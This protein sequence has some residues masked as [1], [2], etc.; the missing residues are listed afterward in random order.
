M[1]Y[2]LLIFKFTIGLVNLQE[3]TSSNLPI[4]VINTQG[5]EIKNEPR[6]EVSM[7][8]IFNGSELR[9]NINDPFNN[10]YGNISIEVRG[11]SSQIFPKKSYS[12]E[13]ITESGENNNV[14]LL[15]MPKENDWILYAPYSDKSLMRNVLSYRISNE[16]GLYAPRTEFCELVIDSIYQ[17]V[18]VLVEKI[19]KDKNRVNIKEPSDSN[20]SGGYLME[21]SPLNKIHPD[22]NYFVAGQTNKPMVVKYPKEENITVD[23]FNWIS[24]HINS[25]EEALYGDGN[26]L[27]FI[28]IDSF[29]DYILLNEAFR[30]NDVFFAST[31]FYKDQD[32]KISM[33]PMWDMNIALGNINYNDNWKTEGFWLTQVI[34]VEELLEDSL[35]TD[36]YFKRWKELRKDKLQ[37]ERILNII[38]ST[39]FYLDESQQ[40]NFERWPIFGEYVWPNNFIGETYEEEI[41]YL[42]N[43]ISERF[44]W[45]D[46]N[47]I[48]ALEKDKYIADNFSLFPNFP[49]PFNA[50]TKIQYRLPNS[51]TIKIEIFDLTGLKVMGLLNEFQH[52]GYHSITWDGKNSNGASCSSGLYFY[53]LFINQKLRSTGRM[54][55]IK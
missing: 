42:K 38:D 1:F 46:A 29:I 41:S 11:S 17:G 52:K 32:S 53:S 13:T 25:F 26:P 7:G 4:V 8:V 14:S 31:Y 44:L 2:F 51:E 19:K 45:L 3:F 20:I 50:S 30:N 28:N 55:L 6:I 23:Q 5:Q 40:R 27:S 49:N 48:T 47:L 54:M 37:T 21:M 9:N 34:W 39:K 36:L 10:Y 33:G 16:I 43:W 18:Y 35:F 24:E 15:G 12:F 22:D